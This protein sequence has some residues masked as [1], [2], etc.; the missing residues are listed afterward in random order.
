MI[1]LLRTNDVVTI[2]FVTS[3]LKD[4]GITVM[5]T[6]EYMS[7]A[8]GSLG[9]LPRRI[10]VAAQQAK[11]A[12]QLVRDAGLGAELGGKFRGKNLNE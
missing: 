2:S 12:R 7:V 11:K 9:L 5:V 6:D 3:L 1:E 10:L 8:E 4:A